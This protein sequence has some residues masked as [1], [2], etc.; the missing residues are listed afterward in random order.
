[1]RRALE[2]A[3]DRV[4]VADRRRDRLGTVDHDLGRGHVV[5]RHQAGTLKSFLGDDAAVLAP[6]SG[7]EPGSHGVKFDFHTAV[8][9]R[10]EEAPHR[11]GAS[12]GGVPAV[13][14]GVRAFGSFYFPHAEAPELDLGDVRLEG[15]V[16]PQGQSVD[17]PS[18]TASLFGEHHEALRRLG[19]SRE[20]ERAR[21][22]CRSQLVDLAR[23]GGRDGDAGE[24]EDAAHV[25]FW[26]CNF[27]KPKEMSD[28]RRFDAQ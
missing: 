8:R 23:R 13:A 10:V 7:E 21:A 6:S 19:A 11:A 18:G 25:T 27:V 24:R 3:V 20:I 2:H 28:G 4:V 17:E 9:V 15:A 22:L 1:M 12:F 16:R 26:R 14:R 5:R